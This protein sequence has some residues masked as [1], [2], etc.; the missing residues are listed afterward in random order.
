MAQTA[1]CCHSSEL[2]SG[3]QTSPSAVISLFKRKVSADSGLDALIRKADALRDA[4]DATAAADAYAAALVHA[5][6]RVDLQVQLGNMLKDSG[7]LVEAEPIYRE[8]LEARPN[9]ADIHLQLGHLLKMRGR[10]EEARK[11]YR[12]ALAIDP[13][14]RDARVELLNLGDVDLDAWATRPARYAATF[15]EVSDISRRLTAL[16]SEISALKRMLP[17]RLAMQAFPVEHWA[18]VRRLFTVPPPPVSGI[19]NAAFHVV[20]DGLNGD[21]AEIHARISSLSSQRSATYTAAIIAKGPLAESAARY[22]Q[23][24]RRLRI[25][26]SLVEATEGVKLPV[27]LST[28][29]DRFDPYALAWFGHALRVTG[30]QGVTCDSEVLERTSQA[31]EPGSIVLR[32]PADPDSLLEADLIGSTLAVQADMLVQVLQREPDLSASD[33]VRVLGLHLGCAFR[34]AHVPL[35]L[36]SASQPTSLPIQAYAKLVRRHIDREGI[37]GVSIIPSGADGDAATA[38]AAWSAQPHLRTLSVIIPTLVGGDDV[39]GIVNSLRQHAMRPDSLEIIVVD[40]GCTPQAAAPLR[41]LSR[42]GHVRII[43]APNPFNWAHVNNR[44]AAEATGDALV[45]VNDDMRMLTPGWDDRVRGQLGRRCVGAVGAKLLYPHGPIQ[46]AGV[47]VGWPGG[48]VHD[49]LDRDASDA[50]PANRYAVTRRVAAVTGAFLGVR[51]Q[52]FA[53]LGGFDAV[54]FAISYN[55]VDFCFRLRKAGLAVVW[56]PH[57]VLTHHESKTRGPDNASAETLARQQAEY[58]ALVSLWDHALE[59][60][61]SANPFWVAYGRPLRLIWPPSTEIVEAF[62]ADTGTGADPFALA[63]VTTTLTK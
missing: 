45:F 17:D 27:V 47:L 2:S 37:L 52:D 41:E 58:R 63:E 5:P 53:D 60:D 3:S 10:I 18:D 16:A 22:T 19:V 13:A 23:A 35:P 4:R 61:P 51:R 59:R 34:L 14:C 28:G 21:E 38:E 7:R 55:D 25:A 56:T 11:V 49:G 62:I 39:V 57:I 30:A 12:A 42:N 15:A 43:D 29:R 33:A 20:L 6:E 48:T 40:N 31:D 24:D 50:G 1:T 26:S 8:A 32:S 46:H 9:D 36:V 54:R 44:A